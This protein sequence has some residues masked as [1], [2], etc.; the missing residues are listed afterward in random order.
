MTAVVLMKNYLKSQK[1]APWIF[2]TIVVCVLKFFKT[3]NDINPSFIKDIFQL[4]ITNR[5]TQEIYKL[6]LEIPKSNQVRFRTK[7]L[8]YLGPKVWDSLPYDI[9]S[10]ENLTIF[11]TLIKNWNATVSRCKIWRKWNHT[12]TFI[13]LS[14]Y[15][16]C[17]YVDFD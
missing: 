3:L 17:T 5:P 14:F 6:N 9:R 13:L 2:P 4:R 15:I 7:S 16:I 11:K 10:S 8:S 1:K 12:L